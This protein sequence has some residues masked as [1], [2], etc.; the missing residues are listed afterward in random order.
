MMLFGLPSRAAAPV[1][2]I[3]I[4]GAL[5]L[6]LTAGLAGLLRTRAA[7][8]RHAVWALGLGVVLLLP[9]AEGILPGWSPS[10][11]NL[12]SPPSRD[13]TVTEQRA[14]RPA[15]GTETAG[16]EPVSPGQERTLQSDAS[17]SGDGDQGAA[18]FFSLGTVDGQGWT[19]VL[20]SIWALGATV[21][22]TWVVAG[23]VQMSRWTRQATLLDSEGWT[24]PLDWARRQIQIEQAIRLYRSNAVSV[25]TT[26][27]VIQPVI[28][29]PASAQA[30]DE[31]RRR[32]VLLHELAHVKR[33]DI[34][35]NLVGQLACAVHWLN[36]LA[37]YGARRLRF[38]RER[39]CD[40]R[41]LATGIS[42]IDYAD[43][44]VSV[45]REASGMAPFQGALAMAAPS[46]LKQRVESL[47]SGTIPRGAPSWTHVTL[48]A[49]PL[50]AATVVLGGAQPISPAPAAGPT[51]SASPPSILKE[52]V[53]VGTAMCD[54]ANTSLPTQSR[55][56]AACEQR[57]YRLPSAGALALRSGAYGPVVVEAWDSSAVAL[58]AT[59]V[60]R[61]SA[62]PDAAEAL[63][64]V[65]LHLEGD[66][67]RANGPTGDAQGWWS[68]DYRL[69]VPR[70]ASLDL[71]TYS[72][73]IQ[74]RNVTGDLRLTSDHGELTVDLPPEIGARLR[75]QTDYGDI[76]VG[77]PVTVQGTVTEELNTTIGDGEAEVR[78]ATGSDITVRRA[79][80]PTDGAP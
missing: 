71:K 2:S 61:R 75:A 54:P 3:L 6:G 66:T 68:V 46:A 32:T 29:L 26:F 53:Q 43:H 78:L 37:W 30:W 65:R 60:T 22:L 28:L 40:D 35:A 76:D 7:A 79:S 18:S 8:Y 19:R 77:F 56:E 80:S 31:Q 17:R 50:L 38:E 73:S 69:R 1:L 62:R 67:I 34:L 10:G 55:F 42:P 20:L 4:E 36:P 59:I 14:E 15:P 13:V 16:V 74:V 58:E 39:A 33:K 41:V 27:G 45:A 57:R 44:L 11:S 21:V 47:L 52:P 51:P 63:S 70:Q 49:I 25:P 23:V 5:L 72:G 12:V 24:A 64:K 48:L 9:L